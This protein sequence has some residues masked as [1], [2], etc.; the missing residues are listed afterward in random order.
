MLRTPLTRQ[1]KGRLR[2][3]IGRAL[4]YSHNFGCCVG[5]EIEFTIM[6]TRITYLNNSN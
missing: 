2:S 6:S 5:E 3:P 4:Y 1:P